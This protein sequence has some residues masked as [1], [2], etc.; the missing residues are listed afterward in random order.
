MDQLLDENLS[1]QLNTMKIV[2]RLSLDIVDMQK[3]MNDMQ[4]LL[5]SL[6]ENQEVVRHTCMLHNYA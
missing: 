6:I 2:K 4:E 1:S 5:S 3:S